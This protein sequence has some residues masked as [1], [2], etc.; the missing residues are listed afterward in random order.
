MQPPYSNHRPPQTTIEKDGI[1]T[2][3]SIDGLMQRNSGEQL[4]LHLT[5][6]GQ[7]YLGTFN[8]VHSILYKTLVNLCTSVIKQ[9][10]FVGLYYY[11][12]YCL[13]PMARSLS[14]FSSIM[15]IFL[16]ICDPSK[17]YMTNL[18]QVQLPPLVVHSSH[19]IFPS[20]STI[21]LPSYVPV[22]FMSC[23]PILSSSFMKC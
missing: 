23:K 3:A 19:E 8:I 16:N 9:V 2:G 11:Y 10:I 13:V 5:K 22:I 4:M 6:Q 18:R 12:Y 17:M 21:S 20:K 7:S 15:I 1:Y 14:N